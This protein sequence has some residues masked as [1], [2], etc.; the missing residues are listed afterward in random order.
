[1]TTDL[2][3]PES[4]KQLTATPDD[5]AA[6]EALVGRIGWHEMMYRVGQLLAKSHQQAS[7]H[8]QSALRGL[9]NYVNFI[10]PGA[11]W[12]DHELVLSDHPGS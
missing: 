12:C 11:Y 8:R 5:L 3:E 7:G 10:V 2:Y 4:P 9:A 6:L 1:M